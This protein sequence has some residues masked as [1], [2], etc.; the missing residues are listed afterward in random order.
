[1]KEKKEQLFL[2]PWFSSDM[3]HDDRRHIKCPVSLFTLHPQA[4]GMWISFMFVTVLHEHIV[5]NLISNDGLNTCK[6]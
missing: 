3:A 2:I 1:M 6:G 4:Y 5:G